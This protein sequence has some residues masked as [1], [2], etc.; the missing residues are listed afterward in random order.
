M[1]FFAFFPDDAPRRCAQPET[2]RTNGS[3]GT[4]WLLSFTGGNETVPENLM[5]S[6]FVRVMSVAKANGPEDRGTRT[7]RSPVIPS[8]TFPPTFPG[9][10]KLSEFAVS[11]ANGPEDHGACTIRSPVLRITE[12]PD[13]L[14]RTVD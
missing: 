1:Q 7:G 10:L 13:P 3:R 9:K 5:L 11:I 14:V 2:E 6:V 4:P 12:G 8:K